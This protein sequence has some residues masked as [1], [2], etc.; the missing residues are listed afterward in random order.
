[1]SKRFC[2]AF[3]RRRDPSA[4]MRSMWVLSSRWTLGSEYPALRGVAARITSIRGLPYL[5]FWTKFLQS[6][7]SLCTGWATR[8]SRRQQYQVNALLCRQSRD[9]QSAYVSG[10]TREQRWVSIL[11]QLL[12]EKSCRQWSKFLDRPWRECITADICVV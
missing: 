7:H 1:M 11:N 5:Q 10:I 2:I 12:A 9:F 8:S 6:L 4:K 3:I